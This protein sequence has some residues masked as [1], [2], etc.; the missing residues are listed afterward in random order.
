MAKT[1]RPRTQLEWRAITDGRPEGL[2][3]FLVACDLDGHRVAFR[4][5]YGRDDRLRA[6]GCSVL[7]YAWC[8]L[9]DPP[10]P[11]AFT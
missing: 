10:P 5:T 8:Q 11:T 9:S 1:A 6:V 2:A 3:A 7:P 4:G